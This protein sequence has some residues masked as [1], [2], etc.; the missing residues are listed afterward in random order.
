MSHNR[1]HF[2]C[3]TVNTDQSS[4]QL[5]IKNAFDRLYERSP[6]PELLQSHLGNSPKKRF[7]GTGNAA[8]SERFNQIYASL[9]KTRKPDTSLSNSDHSAS[10]SHNNSFSNDLDHGTPHLNRSTDSVFKSPVQRWV[11]R[12]TSFSISASRLSNK[13]RSNSYIGEFSRRFDLEKDENVRHNI[14]MYG[15]KRDKS[16][17]EFPNRVNSQVAFMDGNSKEEDFVYDSENS[18]NI[19]EGS[20]FRQRHHNHSGRDSGTNKTMSGGYSRS[21][22]QE[23]RRNSDRLE[24]N[25]HREDEST[26]VQTF[27]RLSGNQEILQLASPVIPIQGRGRQ[28]PQT[29]RSVTPVSRD[30]AHSGYEVLTSKAE[31]KR[32]ENSGTEDSGG[33]DIEREYVPTGCERAESDGSVS[34][35]D[36]IPSQEDEISLRLTDH[37]SVREGL[38]SAGDNGLQSLSHKEN[39]GT[40]TD[41][42]EEDPPANP[43]STAMAGEDTAEENGNDEKGSDTREDSEEETTPAAEDKTEDGQDTSEKGSAAGTVVNKEERALYEWIIKPVKTAKG[44]CVEGKQS[45]LANEEFWKSSVIKERISNTKIQTASGTVYK[46][47]GSIDK[48]YA[49]DEGFSKKLVRA[50]KFGFPKNWKQL[51]ADHFDETELH[52]DSEQDCKQEKSVHK[53]PD[54]KHKSKTVKQRETNEKLRTP[55]NPRR[56]KNAENSNTL[57]CTPEGQFV[58]LTNLTKTRSGRMVKPPLFWWMGQQIMT[59]SNKVELSQV[60]SHAKNHIEGIAH[61][62]SGSTRKGKQTSSLNRSYDTKKIRLNKSMNKTVG[63]VLEIEKSYGKVPTTKVNRSRKNKSFTSTSE[64]EGS[65]QNKKMD[66]RKEGKKDTDNSVG[67]TDVDNSSKC[68]DS[69]NMDPVKNIEKTLQNSKRN[70]LKQKSQKDKC[71]D[72]SDS[73]SKREESQGSDVYTISSDD[74]ETRKPRVKRGSSKHQTKNTRKTVSLKDFSTGKQSRSKSSSDEKEKNPN[75]NSV[76]CNKERQTEKMQEVSQDS[77]ETNFRVTRS[78]VSAGAPNYCTSMRSLSHKKNSKVTRSRSRS[79]D[80]DHKRSRSQTKQSEPSRKSSKAEQKVC[81]HSDGE[82]DIDKRTIPLRK[83]RLTKR[84]NPTT[85]LDYS[86]S[87]EYVPQNKKNRIR[88]RTTSNFNKSRGTTEDSDSDDFSQRTGTVVKNRTMSRLQDRKEKNGN[89]AGNV[90]SSLEVK[91]L[92]QAVTSIRADHPDFWDLVQQKVIT[93]T[94]EQCQEHHWKD[95]MA[96]NQKT[97]RRDKS[98]NNGVCDKVVLTAKQGTMKRRQQLRSLMEQHNEGHEDD[99]CDGTPFRNRIKSKVPR[100]GEG[101]EDENEEELFN[102]VKR[103]NPNIA[104]RFHTP[105]PHFHIEP[106]SQ[107][108]TPFNPLISPNEPVNRNEMDR[109]IH[110]VMKRRR[111]GANKQKNKDALKTPVHKPTSRYDKDDVPTPTKKLFD[112]TPGNVDS[113]LMADEKSDSDNHANSDENSD[114]YWT[115]MDQ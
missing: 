102:E 99:L 58:D 97:S 39:K 113:L 94:L 5:I 54:L 92:Q 66:R 22:D 2:G 17:R 18:E 63:N 44:V 28:P 67:G 25:Y 112:V 114:Y 10:F 23:D 9:R 88:K 96:R 74:G 27:E 84:R 46:L 83:P 12:D 30:Q 3:S 108:K 76:Q 60:T 107:K 109:Y 20:D 42:E 49:L 24:W 73:T 19:E 62:Y 111:L 81:N 77:E 98:V 15:E 101:S 95:S 11:D 32:K 89:E 68:S 41:T 57:V 91:R 86:S 72:D 48:V 106:V 34:D 13:N 56:T 78:R 51:I 82:S 69:E 110:R 71:Y 26:G 75:H 16:I 65:R 80:A 14:E 105:V 64:V 43:R 4:Q 38:G 8:P 103:Q 33:S 115:D 90:W 85:V 21:Y 6:L 35:I 52:N 1:S 55:I 87:E 100:M 7:S 29:Q 45:E 61:I 59:D 50:F 70:R 31:T 104:N 40:E 47:F 79:Q 37:N 93:K 36:L 53:K